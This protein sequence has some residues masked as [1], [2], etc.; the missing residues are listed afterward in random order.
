MNRLLITKL[1]AHTR[2]LK[3]YIGHVNTSVKVHGRMQSTATRQLGAMRITPPSMVRGSHPTAPLSL[4]N[5]KLAYI[6]NSPSYNSRML[7]KVL[8]II[9][10]I[11]EQN[12]KFD[13]H[14]YTALLAAYARSNKLYDVKRTLESMENDKFEP[15]VDTYNIIL[16]GFT[17]SA[18]F[19]AQAHILSEMKKKG[20]EKTPASYY[21]VV[22]ALAKGDYLEQAIDAVESM[23]EEGIQLNLACCSH[24]VS[25]CLR[26]KEAGLAYDILKDCI[27]RGLALQGQTTM[28]MN[29]LRAVADDDQCEAAAF[30]WDKAVNECSMRPDE[31]TCLSVIRIAA[32]AGNVK[33][34]TNVIQ[35]LGIQGYPYKEHYFT[36]LMEAFV[37]KN[38]LKNAFNVLDIM[39]SSGVTPTHAVTLLIRDKIYSKVEDI[40]NAY[41]LL[42]EL[43][44]EGKRVD[45]AAFNVIIES[46]AVAGDIERTVATYRE[47][48]ALGVVPDIDT[49]HAVLQ[50][51]IRTSNKLMGSVVIDEMRKAGISPN[52]DTYTKMIELSCTQRDYEDAF[53]YLEEMKAF[54]VVPSS[55]AYLSLVRKLQRESDPRIQIALEEMETFGHRLPRL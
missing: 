14:T 28:Y 44:A 38:D 31:G 11:K 18:N 53:K 8:T 7:N 34:A 32:K 25:A 35:Q 9:R 3:N 45:I 40:D 42:E 52:A 20:I 37:V 29:V 36:P 50:G 12:L 30:C 33:L 27:D 1:Q 39:R 51:C 23:K 19:K 26:L 41:F 2:P 13:R 24:I 55:A 4:F 15:T 21:H 46:C 10:E 17:E 47:A 22:H 6:I 54:G 49:Y 43:K 48:A 16:Q 5:H